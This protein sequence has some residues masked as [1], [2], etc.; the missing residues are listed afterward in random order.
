MFD[1]CELFNQRAAHCQLN[2]A[3][4]EHSAGPS[5]PPRYRS[6]PG[7]Y[8]SSRG[9]AGAGPAIDA[10]EYEGF[11]RDDGEEEEG[12]DSRM[13]QAVSLPERHLRQG[14]P[15]MTDSW[16]LDSSRRQNCRH[17]N[18]PCSPYRSS[19]TLRRQTSS[20]SCRRTTSY[21]WLHTLY[22]SSSS[23]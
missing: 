19:S 10:V 15:L 5:N 2:N 12:E 3:V 14:T 4:V 23:I 9:T 18:C 20:R 7:G 13:V 1:D 8:G 16:R 17:L 21:S 22:R 11:E 6:G